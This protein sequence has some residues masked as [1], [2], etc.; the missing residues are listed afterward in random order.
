VLDED[1]L[2]SGATF[3]ARLEKGTKLLQDSDFQGVAEDVREKGAEILYS[4]S[5]RGGLFNL[6][7]PNAQSSQRSI[8]SAQM[9]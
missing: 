3:L 8:L 7:G 6:G 4:L 5:V 2:G 9:D 1:V